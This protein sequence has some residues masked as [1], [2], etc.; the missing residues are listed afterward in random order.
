MLNLVF[1]FLGSD[2][3][4][5][6]YA[7]DQGD[8][9]LTVRAGFDGYCKEGYWFPVR[10]EVQNSGPDLNAMVQVTYK[11]G[12]GGNSA[13]SME[14]ALPSTSHKEVVLYVFPQG[15]MRD[16]KVSL[17]VGRRTVGETSI[18]V[19]CLGEENLLFGVLSGTPST[20]DVLNDVKP[21]KGF[22]RVAQL[23]LSDLPDRGQALASLDAL[24]VSNTDTAT[25]SMEQEKA[26]ELWISG[27]GKLLVIGGANWQPTT[28]GIQEFVP[29]EIQSTQNVTSLS[30]LQ[31]YLSDSNPLELG[32]IT[33]V[34]KLREGADVLVKQN[35]VP[36]LI[37]KQMGFGKVYFLAVDPG[38]RPLSDWGGMKSFYDLLLGNKPPLPAWMTGNYVGYNTN[39]ALGALDEL[40]VPSTIYVCSLLALYVLIIG[41]INYLVLRFAK[42]REM[43]WV[44]IPVLVILFSCIS[45]G[46]GFLYRGGTP[47]LNR[48][49][50]VQA[51]DGVEN[52]Q[53]HALTGIYSPS[54][55]KYNLQ[56]GD[57]FMP[58]PFEGD[59]GDLQ[60]NKDWNI[61]QT[62]A[63]MVMPNV[64]VEIGGMKVVDLS[65][66][67]PALPIEHNLVL[68]TG[69]QVPDL[70]GEITN[71]SEY[72][73]KDAGIV[74]PVNWR[75]LGDFKPGETKKIDF[76][77][78]GN[79]NTQSFYFQNPTSILGVGN[80]NIQ[81]DRESIRSVAFLRSLLSDSY[82]SRGG[83][84]GILSCR[85]VG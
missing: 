42:R 61:T 77:L 19:K 55:A 10:V 45:Y 78:F 84:W 15:S 50:M 82:Y 13:T 24:V 26:L 40:G 79:S 59:N 73:L 72:T 83:N 1:I 41:P 65:G 63:D 35:G 23:K 18:S 29:V 81:T 16:M 80:S 32:A 34:G 76:S 31:S 70:I 60:E 20:Y 33:A 25:L 53:V 68:V 12:S 37:Q 14:L 62:D 85:M 21:L 17:L 64:G 5:Q 54:R 4:K 9:S 74:T 46:F 2:A 67:I 47:I 36:I 52:A 56:A 28:A 57:Q 7:Q 43:A 3:I 22:A 27:G 6:V 44:S 11:N 66:S 75:S 8:V 69:N 38:L 48:L 49:V 39:Q 58:K 51:W 71:R 30:E